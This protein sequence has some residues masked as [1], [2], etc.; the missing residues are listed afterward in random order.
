MFNRRCHKSLIINSVL[1]FFTGADC[2]P[3][4]GYESGTLTFSWID[5]YQ[6]ASTCAIQLTLPTK[7]NDCDEFKNNLDIAFTMHGGFGLI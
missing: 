5:P 3:P 6:T 2:I 7:Y 4:S 1:A